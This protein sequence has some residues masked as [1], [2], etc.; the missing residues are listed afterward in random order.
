MDRFG[1][2][3]EISARLRHPNILPLYDSGEAG[4]LFYY[5]MYVMP[6]VEGESLREVLNREKQ[7][8]VEDALKIAQEVAE[9]L[10]LAHSHGER[11]N[12]SDNGSR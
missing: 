12:R 5:V 10:A 6:F 3:I 11:A 8:S 1:R 9:A 2:E 7:L 4:G